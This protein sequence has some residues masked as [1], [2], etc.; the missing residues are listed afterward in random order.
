M[1]G[2]QIG[3]LGAETSMSRSQISRSLMPWCDMECSKFLSEFPIV[4]RKTI[5]PYCVTTQ[6]KPLRPVG[7]VC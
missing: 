4:A 6:Q 5:E 7:L 3:F 2:P 1:L